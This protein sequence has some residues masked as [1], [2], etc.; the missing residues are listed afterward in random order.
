LLLLRQTGHGLFLVEDLQEPLPELDAVGGED[1][2]LKRGQR[3]QTPI[4]VPVTN[5][6]E[7]AEVVTAFRE[8]YGPGD[9]AKLCARL[10]VAL[11]VNAAAQ[12]A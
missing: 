7:V 9:I 10:E 3:T 4:A 5:P 12:Q 8:E 1:Q 6:D 11:E 2:L